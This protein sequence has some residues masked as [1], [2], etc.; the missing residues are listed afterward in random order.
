MKANR[1]RYKE[2]A[3]LLGSLL[4]I[5]HSGVV[6]H[7]PRTLGVSSGIIA[8]SSAQNRVSDRMGQWA[9]QWGSVSGTLPWAWRPQHTN[10]DT[11]HKDDPARCHGKRLGRTTDSR[12]G[13]SSQHLTQFHTSFMFILCNQNNKEKYGSVVFDI[14]VCATPTASTCN[15]GLRCVRVL[16]ETGITCKYQ[17]SRCPSPIRIKDHEFSGAEMWLITKTQGRGL[18]RRTEM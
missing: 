13:L 11:P 10:H 8:S 14:E 15:L 6:L 7:F 17:E 5:T 16:W 3:S 9:Q 4:Q 2:A 1:Q 18:R 12:H